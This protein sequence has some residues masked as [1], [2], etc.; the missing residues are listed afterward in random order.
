MADFETQLA[1][2]LRRAIPDFKHLSRAERLSGGASQETYRLEIET[3]AG[4]RTLAM[5]RAPGGEHVEA[6]AGP[7]GLDVEA[8]LMRSARDA[9]VPEPEVF[10]VLE[11]SDGLGDGFIMEWLEGIALGARVVRD[12]SLEEIRPR[13]AYLCGEILARIHAIDLDATGLRSKLDVMSPAEYVEQTWERYRLFDTPQ[14][15]IDYAGQWLLAN[16]PE[17]FTPTLVHNDFRNGNVMFSPEG[18]VAVL[19]WEI[20]HIGDPMRD[21]GWICTNSWRFGR[22]DL[23]VGGFGTYDDL[24]AGYESVSGERVDRDFVIMLSEWSIEPGSRRPNPNEMTDFNVLTMNAKAYPGTPALVCRKGDRVRIRFG[25]LSAMDHHPIHLHGYYFKVV[26]TDGGTIPT[27]AQWPETTVIVPVGSTRDV[28]FVADEPG[29]DFDL[30]AYVEAATQI[31][32]RGGTPVIFPSHGLNGHG[33]QGWLAGYGAIAGEVDRF[34]GFELG[35]MFVPYG[36]IVSLDTYR[37]LLDI[38]QCIGA[39]HSSLD[40]QLEWDRL[41]VRDRVRPDFMVLTGNDLAID[42]VRYGSDY[43]LGLSTFAPDLFA[44]R[45]ALWAAQDARYHELDDLLQYLG[46]FTFR[47]PVPGYRHDAAMVMKLRGWID[48]DAVPA[49]APLRPGSDLAVLAEIVERMERWR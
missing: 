10:Y 13:L 41:A 26:A 23:P 33:D 39:K 6:V 37:G 36:R 31:A 40:R 9:G 29:A 45:D 28:E 46:Q 21:L 44:R 18:V 16:A 2:V 42:M 20:A 14:P 5:R 1:D 48:A 24:F 3:A 22:A 12:P 17:G 4:D 34:I 11:A 8:L 38:P 25:N 19:D 32:D 47:A 49:G 27:S 30:G 7:P 15:M 43:L 35:T